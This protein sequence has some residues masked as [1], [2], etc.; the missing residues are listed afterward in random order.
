M[1]SSSHP[2]RRLRNFV[3][4]R[5]FQLKYSFIIAGLG[6]LIFG[7]MAW[8]FFEKVRE[9]TQLAVIEEVTARAPAPDATPPTTVVITS[10][11]LVPPDGAAMPAKRTGSPDAATDR[12]FEALLKSRLEAED[13][14]TLWTLGGFC[15]LLV[16]LLF[17]VG[18]LATHRIVGP[19][20]VVD[21]YVQR[22]MRGQPVRARALRR[23]DEFQTLF[24]RVNDM[25][26]ALLD[27]RKADLARADEALSLLAA[28]VDGLGEGTVSGDQL[29]GWYQ[30]DLATLRALAD[31]KRAY[32]TE[33]EKG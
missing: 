26:T 4:D 28:R 12:D 30:E 32:V 1:S 21:L 8:L 2:K 23:G 31:E 15:L 17:V 25:A 33:V 20:Y 5:G 16:A 18:I 9:N 13:A 3:L 19:I 24:Q 27:E 22:I 10:E 7:V 14:W 6:G 29:A 11:A